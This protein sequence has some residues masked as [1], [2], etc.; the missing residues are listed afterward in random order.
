[1]L[2]REHRDTAAAERFFRCLRLLADGA[3]PG[4]IT[5]DKLG[6]R[7]AVLTRVP[8]IAVGRACA[9]RS[10]MRCNNR[11]EQTHRP[12]LVGRQQR[13]RGMLLELEGATAR[14]SSAGRTSV[15]FNVFD[16]S[17]AVTRDAEK[18]AAATREQGEI[19]SAL[20][21]PRRACRCRTSREWMDSSLV[22]SV[23]ETSR[24]RA[25]NR[26]GIGRPLAGRECACPL[27]R[28]APLF[29]GA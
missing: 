24:C 25:R 19:A 21:R 14:C 1:V 20:C 2:L 29:A 27:R 6:S 28:S 26:T 13:E 9:A 23:E 17:L 5:A 11:V 7:V 10:A 12:T 8:E 16:D 22:G 15:Q 3:V 4:C 18:A